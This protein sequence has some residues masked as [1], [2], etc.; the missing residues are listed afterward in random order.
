[1][2]QRT[3]AAFDPPMRW[4]LPALIIASAVAEVEAAP[5][6]ELLVWVLWRDRGLE[7]AFRKFEAEYPGWRIV[8][9]YGTGAGG[10]NPQKLLTAVAGGSPPD[11][12]IQDRFSVGEWAV[13]GA[14]AALGDRVARSVQQEEWAEQACQAI[15][16]G[17]HGVAQSLFNQLE[18]SLSIPRQSR[19]AR[20]VTQLAGL[21]ASAKPPSNFLALAKELRSLS[22]G[23]HRRKYYRACWEEASYGEGKARQVYAIPL[24]TDCRALYYNED[25][26]ERAGFA[27]GNG[28]ARPP[29]DWDELKHYAVKLTE[30]DEDGNIT[31][32]GFAPNYGNSWLYL[33]GWLNDGKFMSD[34]GRTCTLSDPRIV[35]ALTY[36]VEIY[37]ALGGIEKVDAFQSSFQGG[38]FDPFLQGKVAMKID[39]NWFLNA[40][41]DHAPNLRFGVSS[42]PPPKGKQSLT[43]SGGFSWVIPA[44]TESP[45]VAFELIRFLMADRIWLYRNEVNARYYT[46]RGRAFIPHMAP[47]PHVN[48]FLYQSSIA[49][50]PDLSRR[51][52]HCV[53][54]FN[55][56]MA[57][58]KFRPVT[59]VGQLLWDEHVRAYEKA[60]RH[61]YSPQ[62]AL[63]RGRRAVQKQLDLLY[64][65]TSYPR[66]RWS[67]VIAGAIAI[68]V[69]GAVAIYCRGGGRDLLRRLA[70]SETRAAVFFASPWLTGLVVFTAGPIVVSLIYSFCRYNVLSP[71]EW[72]GLDHYRRLLS[73]DP[74]LW[75]SLANTAYMMLGIPLG[76]AVGLA[77]A[78]LLN[79]E[80]RGMKVYRT[81][82][83]LPA[84][85][86][87]VA[88]SILWIWVLNPSNGLIN[89]FLKMLGVANPPLWLQSSS[90]LFGSKASIILMGLWGAGAGM[91]IWLAG[92]KGIP[93]YLYE[94][95]QIDGAGPIRKFIHVTLPMLTPYIFFNLIMGMIGTMQIFTQA[96]IMTQGGPDDSTMF[97]AYYLFNNAFR[98]FKMGYASAMAWIL[99]LIILALTLAQMTLAKRWVYYEHE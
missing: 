7:A 41:S 84:I 92:L 11:L 45:D 42:A 70:R 74:L 6:R 55:E 40:I 26:L 20:L 9:S 32:L 68:L 77:I 94:A 28:Q 8:T 97:Y 62:E 59:P 88:S 76:M 80:V 56:L 39:G 48:T 31:R 86:P 85:V 90:W 14:L 66:V 67:R 22:G 44:G 13:R 75:K 91:I 89:S 49:D 83:Y 73:D 36:M 25:L 34:D 21:R 15:V 4:A 10:M 99:F 64:A 72:V 82:F 35:E 53:P 93:S 50:N 33:Y 52:K 43:W 46:S 95:A 78:M 30:H 60:V 17:Q 54:L 1:M 24:G 29:V 37:D 5:T 2:K 51:V 81:I 3:R 96:Y 71:A 57:V 27:D 38:E 63:E 58:S 69:A 98:Y 65:E 23:I 47:M 12:L 18:R 87:V 19:R 79:T 16:R 61:T